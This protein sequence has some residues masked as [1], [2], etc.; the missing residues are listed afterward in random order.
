MKKLIKHRIGFYQKLTKEGFNII[1]IK[2]FSLS[3]KTKGHKPN[4]KEWTKYQKEGVKIDEVENWFKNKDTVSF[5]LVTGYNDLEVIDV[6]SKIFPTK[7][8]RDKFLKEYFELLDNH[9]ENFYEKVCIAKTQS[10]GFHI[11]YKCK[12]ISGNQKIATPKSYKEA[13]IETRGTGGFVYIYN[14]VKG[15]QYHEIDY[16]SE[17]DRQMI[18]E[19]SK[20]Y[21]YQEPL[22][23]KVKPQKTIQKD[24][25]TVW[26]DFAQKNSILDICSS[27]FDVVRH[28]SKSIMIKRKGASSAYSGHIFDDSGKMFLF[29]T[30]TIYPA[31]KPLNSFDVYTWKHHN[32]D[33]SESTRAAYYDGYGAR[34]VS[35]PIEVDDQV[36]EVVKDLDFPIDIFPKEIQTYIVECHNKLNSSVDFMGVAFLWLLSVLIGNTLKVKV[37]NGWI[38]SPILWISVI[39]EAGVGK[40][41]DLKMILKP[42]LDLNAAEI[43]KFNKR[44]KEFNNYEK[45]SKEDKEVN[46]TIEQPIKEQLIVDDITIESL[47][48]V[49]SYNQKS[50]GVFKDELAGWFKDM[51]KYRDGSDKERYLSAWSGDSIAL[52]RKTSD[53]AFVEHPFIPILGGIQP[54]I[55]REF[56]TSENHSNGFMDRMLFCDPKKIA[57]YPTDEEL[58]E[59]LINQYREVVFKIRELVD[60]ELTIYEDG[61]I[62]PKILPFNEKAKK[63]YKK[64]HKKLIDLMNSEE[65][66][67]RFKGMFAKQ[68]TYIPRFALL[69]EFINCLFNDEMAAGVSVDSIQKATKLSDYFISMAKKNSI[70]NMASS[71]IDA[72]IKKN[73]GK[74]N[75]HLAQ[76]MVVLFPKTTKKQLAE[77]LGVSRVT[78]NK[79][80][81]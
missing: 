61:T 32:G 16:I 3:N 62:Q 7:K 24:G 64:S 34:Y 79:Y 12:E 72:F 73:Q 27:D 49:H 5:G 43:K 81:K 77:I 48:D 23:P 25:L 22:K 57:Q 67:S 54:N 78:L 50:I 13:L 45:L 36:L 46:E 19:I 31:E 11:L 69:L 70:E 28:T 21:H 66:L 9:I 17:K 6:D 65:E 74:T 68:I 20:T 40:T 75:K 52:N 1:P 47:V 42:L 33:Y 71:K 41:P 51:N 38:D 39:G 56:Q 76:K 58:S 63:E 59:N 35:E 44:M 18:W 55:F 4:L 14:Q 37:K 2:E 30:G 10:G 29:S 60:N 53:D 80:L 8:E 15:V 26:D